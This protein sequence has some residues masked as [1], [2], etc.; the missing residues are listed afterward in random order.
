[1]A[2]TG[3]ATFPVDARLKTV[4]NGASDGCKSLCCVGTAGVP[5]RHQ[6]LSGVAI[7]ASARAEIRRADVAVSPGHH[8]SLCRREERPPPEFTEAYTSYPLPTLSAI[9][10]SIRS[11]VPPSDFITQLI[12]NTRP[13]MGAAASSVDEASPHVD[14]AVSPAD[15]ASPFMDTASPPVDDAPPFMKTASPFMDD[16][17]SPEDE[18]V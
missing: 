4:E 2:S 3:V 6:T 9:V 18:A 5:G 1:M 7:P 15:D 16:A 14:P 8:G 12:R 17:L 10:Q 11:L 13:P